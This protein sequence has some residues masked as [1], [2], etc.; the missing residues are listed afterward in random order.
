MYILASFVKNKV[1]IGAWV[2]FWTFYNESTHT[3]PEQKKWGKDR[4]KRHR[5]QLR[6]TRGASG[7]GIS[8]AIKSKLTLGGWRLCLGW[9]P[10]LWA[11]S[12]RQHANSGRSATCAWQGSSSVPPHSTVVAPRPLLPTSQP[13][14]PAIKMA[15]RG[16][17]HN[18]DSRQTQ[19]RRQALTSL[20]VQWFL[21]R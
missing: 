3:V 7:V 21:S 1:P 20:A 11:D 16:L 6:R 9:N 8:R 5:T 19:H 2:Y 4:N 12:G 17:L 10:C 18:L 14:H 15:L 13:P